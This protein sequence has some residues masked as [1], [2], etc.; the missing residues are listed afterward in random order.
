MVVEVI[1]T[2][3]ELLLGEILNTNFQYLSRHLNSLG[4]DVLYQTTIGDNPVRMRAA[5]EHALE[6]ADIVITSGGLGPTRGDITKEVVME[7][8]GLE[9]YTD[10][11]TLCRLYD[12]LA[13]KGV[14]PTPNNEKQAI[15]PF[16]ADVLENPAG[17]A[18][19]LW[20][21][22]Q[23]KIIILL[24]GPPHEVEAVC[25]TQ[26]WPRLQKNFPDNGVIIS[27]TL[28]L[29]G[30]GESAVA[31]K[32]DDLIVNQSNPTL[33]IYARHGQILIRITT[34]TK[35]PEEAKALIGDMEAQLRAR[36][37]QYIYG[38]DNDSV[39]SVL[40]TKLNLLGKTIAFAE[41]CSGGL[42]SSLITD[43]PGSSEYLKGSVV[44]Y[45]NEVKENVLG[46]K[47]ET[48]KKFGAVSSQCACEM[49]AGVRRLMNSDYGI[50]ITGNAG[51]SP[52]E[53][54][55]V[56]LVYIAVANREIVYWQEHHFD[57]NRTENKLRIAEAAI[58][59]LIEKLQQL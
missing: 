26:L 48:L 18:P 11:S 44:S 32:I 45:T 5:I 24:P 47:P 34:K 56:G 43:I 2:G 58:S 46:V 49:A 10:F 59:T 30:I 1:N 55:P 23:G 52:S 8:C 54:K 38:A 50:S 15:V 31:T 17:T 3:T 19:G 6:R 9:G 14:E 42:A 4:F 53:G 12:F 7:I 16:G 21:E 37:E 29:K 20:L 13:A 39:A 33:A 57:G 35:T 27:R 36:L 28:R 41:S 40:G 22:H 51:P 25:E